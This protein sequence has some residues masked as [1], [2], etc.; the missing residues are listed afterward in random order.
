M[1]IYYAM[2]ISPILFIH[3][4]SDNRKE[5]QKQLLPVRLELL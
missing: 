1:T 4:W 2:L 3:T 5:I